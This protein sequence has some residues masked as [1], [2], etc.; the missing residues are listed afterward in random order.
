MRRITTITV[1]TLLAAGLLVLSSCGGKSGE[2]KQAA[3]EKET[4]STPAV[5]VADAPL[6]AEIE[7]AGFKPIFYSKFP[8]QL[9]GIK[10]DVVVY[11]A[12]KGSAGG[13]LYVQEYGN[14]YR[15]VWHWYFASDA[16][17][18]VHAVEINEDGLWDMR[19]WVG[20]ETRDYVQDQSFTLTARQRDGL[21][22]MNGDASEPVDAAGMLWHAFD[23][24]TTSAWSSDLGGA[25]ID[26]PVPL[27]ID[28]GILAVRLLPEGQPDKVEVK[29]DGKKVQE[30]ELDQTTL[31]QAI[32][33]DPAAKNAD[34][35]RL[36]FKSAHRGADKVSVAELGLK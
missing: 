26:L 14:Q 35:L 32:Q 8:S 15:P 2:E 34:T 20:G 36:E 25:F 12:D 21:V 9:P 1:C 17:D 33:L 4:K 31:E 19:M 7:K 22:A 24:D 23:G 18:S 11:R 30:F 29:A 13:V 10:S 3:G 28:A 16:P 6:K 5:V 27:G